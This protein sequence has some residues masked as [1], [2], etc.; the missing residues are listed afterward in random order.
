MPT[1]RPHQASTRNAGPS[2]KKNAWPDAENTH[3]TKPKSLGPTCRALHELARLSIAAV[4]VEPKDDEL[5]GLA[6]APWR[7][8]ETRHVYTRWRQAKADAIQR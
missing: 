8:G 6:R 3:A 2:A 7:G 5:C 1:R 4:V